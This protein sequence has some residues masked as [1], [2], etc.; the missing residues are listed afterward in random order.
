MSDYILRPES[1]RFL[2]ASGLLLLQAATIALGERRTKADLELQDAIGREW[3]RRNRP[4]QLAPVAGE[5][6][7]LRIIVEGGDGDACA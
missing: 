2:S 7:H 4:S 6:T 5:Q 1:L 3:N